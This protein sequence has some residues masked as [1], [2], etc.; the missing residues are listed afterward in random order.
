MNFLKPKESKNLFEKLNFD[1]LSIFLNKINI[2]DKEFTS[3]QKVSINFPNLNS[4]SKRDNF[5]ISLEPSNSNLEEPSIKTSLFKYVIDIEKLFKLYNDEINLY[6]KE[7]FI[8][9]ID[10]FVI[11]LNNFNDC[12]FKLN[13][14][15]INCFKERE[16][17]ILNLNDNKDKNIYTPSL[18]KLNNN[19]NKLLENED[20]DIE[21]KN[22]YYLLNIFTVF[23]TMKYKQFDLDNL[24]PNI[25]IYN[26]LFINDLRI[27]ILIHFQMAIFV[28]LSLKIVS[29]NLFLNENPKKKN[30]NSSSI[31]NYFPN[32]YFYEN[33]NKSPILEKNTNESILNEQ[34]INIEIY[35]KLF[36]ISYFVI[37]GLKIKLN[38]II[39]FLSN[40]QYLKEN[41]KKPSPNFLYDNNLIL[42]NVDFIKIIINN[43]D[44]NNLLFKLNSDLTLKE[45]ESLYKLYNPLILSSKGFSSDSNLFYNRQNIFPFSYYLNEIDILI[46]AIKLNI[47]IKKIKKSKNKDKKNFQYY[48]TFSYNSF[49]IA[50][51]KIFSKSTNNE[52]RDLMIFLHSFHYSENDMLDYLKYSNNL[53][54]LYTKFKT[55]I[56]LLINFKN[57]NIS[58]RLCEK[59]LDNNELKYYLGILFLQLQNYINE[60]NNLYKNVSLSD[61]ILISNKC[62]MIINNKLKLRENYIKNNI[63]I[64]NNKFD[65]ILDIYKEL[66]SFFTEI[67]LFDNFKQTNCKFN[68]LIILKK[69]NNNKLFIIKNQHDLID[70][71]LYLY[72]ENQ[73]QE[74]SLNKILDLI[75]KTIKNKID[76]N[77]ITFI[78]H[79]DYFNIINFIQVYS[80]QLFIHE[81]ILIKIYLID[82]KNKIDYILN[83]KKIILYNYD[84][85]EI[86]ENNAIAIV[87]ILNKNFEMLKNIINLKEIK[88]Y[89]NLGIIYL[90]KIFIYKEGNFFFKKITNKSLKD[91]N[92]E[93]IFKFYNSIPLFIFKLFKEN[94]NFNL[95][96]LLFVFENNILNK[97]NSKKY[98]NE[99]KNLILSAVK[100]FFEINYEYYY[101]L[102]LNEK[103]IKYINK[104]FIN[105]N[106]EE[107]EKENKIEIKNKF[108]KEVIFPL[109]LKCIENFQ[110]LNVISNNALIFKIIDINNNLYNINEIGK[111]FGLKKIEK[112]ITEFELNA[113]VNK[114][115]EKIEI[116]EIKYDNFANIIRKFNRRVTLI[117]FSENE[118]NENKNKKN[119]KKNKKD[120]IIF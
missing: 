39:L 34:L 91:L 16:L 23:N 50:T 53:F 43:F 1:N 76:I 86:F 44:I 4:S 115:I 80:E 68:P 110:N 73:E 89:N 52:T 117:G 54:T 41:I 84:D 57:Y 60:K 108:K 113:K 95:S 36:L 99:K 11:L 72:I 2:I 33:F 30:N 45:L 32:V 116:Y 107:K 100:N 42:N 31:N 37:N 102:I 74:I 20:Y 26:D 5:D 19:F 82:N 78:V 71:Y 88:N 9:I 64:F 15:N 79:K 65:F 21:T 46:W 22:I 24:L 38:I 94:N 47:N 3:E 12:L 58:L 6:T 98:I 106:L 81:N 8:K 69:F 35:I 55:I 10:I 51:K 61:D 14:S 103:Y 92:I 118:K 28:N 56:K 7:E 70:I 77:S 25:N 75:L 13:L 120:C 87:N 112:I 101:P 40:I 104:I 85:T 111:I 119:K 105:D 109:N 17:T 83:N 90:N 48:F 63:K 93:K 29:V 96:Y 114:D 62:S 67:L 66:F 97:I 59:E 27:Q 49:S 18:E